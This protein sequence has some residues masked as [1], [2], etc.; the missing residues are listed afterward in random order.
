MYSTTLLYDCIV[1]PSIT[2]EYY[3]V[4]ENLAHSLESTGEVVSMEQARAALEEI[5][6]ELDLVFPLN[7]S[8]AQ[9]ATL[10]RILTN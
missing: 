7:T 9:I 2:V 10:R 6:Q 3:R 5:G 4:M 1:V 8:Q